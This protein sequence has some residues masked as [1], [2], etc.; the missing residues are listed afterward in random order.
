MLAVLLLSV[1]LGLVGLALDRAFHNSNEAALQTRM[2][3]LV[4]LVLAATDVSENGVLT[5][6]DDPGDPRLGQPGSGIYASVSGDTEQWVSPS[7]LG[8]SLPELVAAH[9]GDA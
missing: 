8:V 3:S 9:T 2:E 5:V 6:D 7:S 1:S 4:Y